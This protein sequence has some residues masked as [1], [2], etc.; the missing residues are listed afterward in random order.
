MGRPAVASVKG[1]GMVILAPL[2]SAGVEA[3]SWPGKDLIWRTPEGM[4]VTASPV[5][6]DLDGDGTAEVLLVDRRGDALQVLRRDAQKVYRYSESIPCGRIDL[7]G[8]QVLDLDG[9]GRDDILLFGKDRFWWIP[10]GRPEMT[11][12]SL[13]TYDPPKP[14]TRYQ[15][16][17]SGDLNGDGQPDLVLLDACASHLVSLIG[18]NPDGFAQNVLNFPVFESDP[19]YQG[20][21]GGAQEPR[22][23]LVVD[24]TG[25]GKQDLVLLAH[26]RLLIYT[27]K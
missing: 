8:A 25:D 24:V 22:E 10:T 14:E 5:V 17:A 4:G 20:H 9:N 26:D 18:L 13:G 19:H 23:A 27:Q 16:L 15:A 21:K 11:L 12:K 3:F 2:G 1:V 7:V 6:S